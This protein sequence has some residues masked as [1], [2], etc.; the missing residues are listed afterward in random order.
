[1]LSFIQNE[2][3]EEKRGYLL[4]KTPYMSKNDL[5]KICLSERFCRIINRFFYFSAIRDLYTWAVTS[6]EINKDTIR[7][8]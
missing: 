6:I 4:T 7:I 8:M 5:F 2:D 3:E 1:M